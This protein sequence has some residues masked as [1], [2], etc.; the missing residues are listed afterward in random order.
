LTKRSGF[1]IDLIRKRDHSRHGSNVC[2][3]R[4]PPRSRYFMVWAYNGPRLQLGL[5]RASPTIKS[6]RLRQQMML[7]CFSFD[8]ASAA[9]R[10]P[11]LNLAFGLGG[12]M[13]VLSSCCTFL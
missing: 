6:A 8:G 2:C 11:I 4:L 10:L 5:D 13:M 3:S 12:A 1:V 7:Y 9:I